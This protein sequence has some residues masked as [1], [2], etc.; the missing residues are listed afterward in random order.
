MHFRE[1][2]VFIVG[3]Q[4]DSTV[5]D[6]KNAL[7]EK[8]QVSNSRIKLIFKSCILKDD[9]QLVIS[10]DFEE[11]FP[12]TCFIKPASSPTKQQ[13][14]DVPPKAAVPP[15]NP[16][17]IPPQNPEQPPS[18]N[19]KQIIPA[20]PEQVPQEVTKSE[21]SQL[22]QEIKTDAIN[23]FNT[24]LNDPITSLCSYGFSREQVEEALRICKGD[25]GWA[26]ELLLSDDVSED[27][28][29]NLVQ[30]Y[31]PNYQQ[32]Q[33]VGRQ[34]NKVIMM[35]AYPN[36][37]IQ[38]HKAEADAMK[39]SF[40]QIYNEMD[41]NDKNN[42]NALRDRG[43]ELE[44]AIDLYLQCEFNFEMAQKYVESFKQQTKPQVQYIVY[45]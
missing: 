8:Y 30:K 22:S 36:E 41:E 23:D 10:I 17:Q 31:Y 32:M 19:P 39:Q 12:I 9:D 4:P 29:H 7:A 34:G 28:F 43:L 21:T 33:V 35:A 1:K 6:L 5:L 40:L 15:Q 3:L 44:Y 11:K 16:D 13:A 14:S 18:T 20:N 38:K 26:R 42:V 45:Q 24:L 27:G 2:K 37:E 25:A